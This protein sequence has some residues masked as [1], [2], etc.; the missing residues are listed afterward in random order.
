MTMTVTMPITTNFKKG[1]CYYYHCYNSLVVSS[2][3]LLS[4]IIVSSQCFV[5][6][7]LFVLQNKRHRDHHEIVVPAFQKTAMVKNYNKNMKTSSLL[8][9]SWHDYS[10]DPRDDASL[11]IPDMDDVDILLGERVKCKKRKMFD[12]ADDLREILKTEY[13]VY[14]D[15]RSRVFFRDADLL[16][17]GGDG[18]ASNA[19]DPFFADRDVS[20]PKSR[21]SKRNVRDFGPKGHDY[22]RASNEFSEECIFTES[23]IDD[24]LAERLQAKLSRDFRTADS[25]QEKLWD[26]GVAVHDGQKLWRA[27][28][29]SFGASNGPKAGTERGSRA[30][31]NRPYEISE[32][33][34]ELED[35]DDVKF[36]VDMVERRREAKADRE[37]DLADDIRDDLRERLN[38]EIDDRLRQWSVGGKF[39]YDK[40]DEQRLPQR[41]LIEYTESEASTG[42]IDSSERE[43]IINMVRQRSEAKGVRDF[44]TADSIRHRLEEEHNVAI[45]DRSKTWSVG[46][47]FG[48][49]DNR[50]TRD[51]YKFDGD[52]D[53]LSISEKAV[54][55]IEQLLIKRLKAKKNRDYEEA[56]LIRDKLRKMANIG[57]DD[58]QKIWFFEGSQNKDSISN[59]KVEDGSNYDDLR[60][61]SQED[62]DNYIKLTEK[63]P[64]EVFAVDQYKKCTD[65][66]SVPEENYIQE[67]LDRMLEA[68]KDGDYSTG[69]AI[70]SMALFT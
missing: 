9:S 22:D 6:F 40:L 1:K 64:P 49:N 65:V 42:V 11:E 52:V 55:M 29:V 20:R 59:N 35:P 28:G 27:D 23:E 47:D 30:D 24:M 44:R 50:L 54:Q 66:P 51:E 25:I 60:F 63:V 34:Q 31:R 53:S 3:L 17:R 39:N 8:L 16:K 21:S 32:L 45:D 37:Y 36:V 26:G 13:G 5:P 38:I 10:R 15:D 62:D 19:D 41:T 68:E 61:A 18:R 4:C 43:L 58:R 69:Y 46:G 33:S 7:K 70:V 56:D 2:L 57:I 48:G 12:E 67:R 14:V